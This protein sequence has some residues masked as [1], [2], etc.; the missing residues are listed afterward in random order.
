MSIGNIPQGSSAPDPYLEKREDL[1]IIVEGNLC[2]LTEMDERHLPQHVAFL[3]DPEVSQFLRTRPPITL[4]HQTT[5]LKKMQQDPSSKVFAVFAKEAGD[6]FKFVGVIDFHHMDPITQ[7]T[8][9]GTVIGEK[10]YWKK[11]IATEARVLQL[12]Y[13]FSKLGIEWA[14]SRTI[15]P[16]IAS[17]RLLEGIGY[18]L[19]ETKPGARIV[20]GVPQDELIYKLTKADFYLKWGAQLSSLL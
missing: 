11:G 13:G 7:E 3:N 2:A 6:T 4:A 12:H 1:N 16:N 17:Q 10:T 18:Q 9:S 20:D 8:S 14:R 19:V 15:A 5:W